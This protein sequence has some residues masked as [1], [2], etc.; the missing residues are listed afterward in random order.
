MT[1]FIIIVI[2]LVVTWYSVRMHFR[3]K[4]KKHNL[5][6]DNHLQISADILL[7]WIEHI[8]ISHKLLAQVEHD[9]SMSMYGDK[10]YIRI[11]IA[12]YI[13]QWHVIIQWPPGT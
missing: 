12:A 4:N 5:L 6:W 13:A 7:S 1:L 9:L 3:Y 2:L 10:S 8:N 11:L